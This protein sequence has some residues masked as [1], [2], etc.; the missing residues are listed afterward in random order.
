MH[1]TD[2]DKQEPVMNHRRDENLRVGARAFQEDEKSFQV[3]WTLVNDSAHPVV[4]LRHLFRDFDEKGRLKVDPHLAYVSV[5]ECGDITLAKKM[6]P[7]PKRGIHVAVPFVPL[8]EELVPGKSVTE[9]L[10]L[11]VPLSPWNPYEELIQRHTSYPAMKK[12]PARAL[13]VQLGVYRQPPE[14]KPWLVDTAL[15]QLIFPNYD[16]VLEAQLILE[17]PPIPWA[18]GVY[19]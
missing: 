19:A 9:R 15:G 5:A 4:V 8:G 17:S 11:P 18:G 13:R 3:E 1:Q 7:L 10:T 12:V 14:T 2:S 16:Q 6:L